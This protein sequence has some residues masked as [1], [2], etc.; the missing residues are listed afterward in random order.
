M[1]TKLLRQSSLNVWEH[2]M[3]VRQNHTLS[4]A[5]SSSATKSLNT[6]FPCAPWYVLDADAASGYLFR[7]DYGVSRSRSLYR[8]A[9][10][11]PN[12]NLI[13]LLEIDDIVE[14]K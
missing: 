1:T 6:S 13:W 4:R 5:R 2:L 10:S 8:K 14:A 11:R 9:L 3:S 7:C 12:S